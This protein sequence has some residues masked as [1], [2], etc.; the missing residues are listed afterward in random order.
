MQTAASGNG[1]NWEEIDGKEL[2]SLVVAPDFSNGR[3]ENILLS[4]EVV[5]LY[6]C[7]IDSE[8]DCN[9]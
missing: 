6:N 4:K 7:F 5:A 3:K 8:N 1:T 9:P 2:K